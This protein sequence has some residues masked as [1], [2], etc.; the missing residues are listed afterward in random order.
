MSQLQRIAEYL[1]KGHSLTHRQAVLE[2][3]ICALSQRIGNLVRDG[4]PIERKWVTKNGKTYRS[5]RRKGGKKLSH[6]DAMFAKQ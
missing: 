6:W 4:Y 5:Y 2:M 1:D 3:D